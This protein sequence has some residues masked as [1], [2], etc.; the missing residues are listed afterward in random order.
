MI[1]YCLFTWD[2]CNAICRLKWNDRNGKISRW[3]IIHL[4]RFE[5]LLSCQIE[6]DALLQS[7]G[8][9][10]WLVGVGLGSQFRFGIDVRIEKEYFITWVSQ[11]FG[12]TSF[13][14]RCQRLVG[15]FLRNDK[16]R[17]GDGGRCAANRLKAIENVSHRTFR[18]SPTHHEILSL[19]TV[20]LTS[21]CQKACVSFTMFVANSAFFASPSNA[22]WFS[23]LPSGI[24]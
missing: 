8:Y 13:V 12:D 21:C 16:R 9:R 4:I 10:L 19:S 5:H 18:L 11:W 2:G 15:L 23:G 24:L 22:N 17:V 1:S 6:C 3:L 20:L 7:I 14:G